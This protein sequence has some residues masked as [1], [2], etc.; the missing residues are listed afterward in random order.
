MIDIGFTHIALPVSDVDRTIEFYS[1]YAGMQVVHRRID[2]EAGVAVVWLSDRTRPFVIVL[3][4][5][6][7]VPRSVSLGTPRSRLQK[8]RIHG[9][10]LRESTSRRRAA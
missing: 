3:I 9:R 2:A 8:P 7:S 1:K 4:Q 5:T 10:T 6:D